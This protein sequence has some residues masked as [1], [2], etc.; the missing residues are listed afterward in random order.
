M[1][2]QAPDAW[3]LLIRVEQHLRAMNV[4]IAAQPAGTTAQAGSCAAIIT[5]MALRCCSMRL[6]T[7][8]A[9]GACTVMGSAATRMDVVPAY[10]MM[11]VCRPTAVPH[12]PLTHRSELQALH[13]HTC[14][15]CSQYT[16]LSMFPFSTATA[17]TETDQLLKSPALAAAASFSHA[18]RHQCSQPDNMHETV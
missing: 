1:T 15:A 6:N 14:P 17:D 4:L 9:P 3:F 11:R 2:V 10:V 12:Y 13:S 8:Q 5:F 16:A 7:N 18:G